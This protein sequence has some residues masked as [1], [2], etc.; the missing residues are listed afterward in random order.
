M[1]K[2]SGV[3]KIGDWKT[4]EKNNPAV[5]LDFF[6]TIEMEICPVYISKFN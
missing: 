6:Y 3:Q 1:E 4:F 5:V 2:L